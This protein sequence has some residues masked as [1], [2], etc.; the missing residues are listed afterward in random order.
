MLKFAQT[1]DA[2]AATT[3]KLEKTALVADLLKVTPLDDAATA[4]IFL[5]GRPFPPTRKQLWQVGG[6]LLW[7]VI[8]DLS[9]KNRRGVCRRFTGGMATSAPWPPRRYPQ[10]R[11]LVSRSPKCGACSH[12]SLP[13]AGP[14]L[15]LR[16]FAR[17]LNVRP[18]LRPSTSLRSSAVICASA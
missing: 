13:Y 1:C 11:N 17:F 2:I 8:E 6:A 4:A 15:R 12:R 10:N 5:S 7:R 18:R 3:K 14:R 16:F 9:G